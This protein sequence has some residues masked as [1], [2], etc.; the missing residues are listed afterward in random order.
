MGTSD[1]E[2]D[3]VVVGA[4]LAGCATTML[5]A[6][7]GLRVALVERSPDAGAYKTAC[8]HFI[9]PSATPTLERLGLVPALEAAGAIPNAL[10][11]WTRYG[12]GRHPGH[13][14][15]PHGYSLRR[16]RLDPLVRSHAA[17]SPGVEL[18]AGLRASA[19]VRDGGRVRGVRATARDGGERELRGR[20]VVA[21]D[22]RASTLADLAGVPARTWPN[23]RFTYFAYFRGLSLAAPGVAQLWMQDPEIAYAFP[24]DDG[25]TLVSY[26]ALQRDRDDFADVDA[27]VRARFAMLP[28]A[29][30]LR[31]G[32]RVSPWIGRLDMPNVFRRGAHAGMALVG[33]AAQASD[34]IWGVGCGWA[35]QGAE[36]LDACVGPALAAGG[37]RELVDGLAAYARRRRRELALHHLAICDYSSGRR[38]RTPERLLFAAAARDRQTAR[39]VHSYA[40]RLIPVHRLVAPRALTRA[41][42]V[43]AGA[44]G[45]RQPPQAGPAAQDAEP[46]HTPAA[47]RRASAG[48]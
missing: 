21:A 9:Q 43:L 3:A 17:A 23:R 28:E 29:P 14:G 32:T 39:H 47:R 31:R 44:A 15:F 22:G 20:L 34:P 12:W 36:W 46:Q 40:A 11:L 24:N 5:L 30:D 10:D 13:D 38:F 45:R 42:L 7:R 4:S 8:T 2:H 48:R 41:A 27:A 1:T 37:E 19:L 6:R 35:L 16:E 26:W 18:L 33:D 25:L